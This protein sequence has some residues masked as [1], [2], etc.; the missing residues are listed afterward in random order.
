MAHGLKLRVLAK[1]IEPEQ[2][3]NFLH[4]H[5]CDYYQGFLFYRPV[6]VIE[7]EA[8][9][10]S[11]QHPGKAAQTADSNENGCR[12]IAAA[13]KNKNLWSL[14]SFSVIHFLKKAEMIEEYQE[15]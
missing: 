2:Q 14:C 6:P 11:T 3:L 13:T 5:G 1:G 4:Q 12:T 9:L 10:Q 7:L 8:L 15:R